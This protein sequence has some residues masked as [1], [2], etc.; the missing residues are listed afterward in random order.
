MYFF[1]YNIARRKIADYRLG[2]LDGIEDRR[3]WVVQE[4]AGWEP[5]APP[6]LLFK[7]LLIVLDT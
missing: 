3:S 7:H 4:E 2:S 1:S 6:M 5:P